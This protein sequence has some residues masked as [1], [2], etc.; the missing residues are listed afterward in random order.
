M[1]TCSKTKMRFFFWNHPTWSI[2]KSHRVSDPDSD[3]TVEPFFLSCWRQRPNWYK[4][5]TTWREM[6]WMLWSQM[7]GLNWWTCFWSFLIWRHIYFKISFILFSLNTVCYPKYPKS[8][9]TF[10][11][12]CKVCNIPG[13]FSVYLVWLESP[14]PWEGGH[15]ASRS[16][17]RTSTG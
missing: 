15:D 3:A 16:A 9:E 17:A 6:I 8:C 2:C 10:V 13:M 12:L 5:V 4:A 1:L 11:I 14:P 7:T